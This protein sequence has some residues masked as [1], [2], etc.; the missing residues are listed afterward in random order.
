MVNDFVAGLAVG[1]LAVLG[2]LWALVVY[3]RELR[4][5]REQLGRRQD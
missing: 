5:H 3:F 4:R 2:W 1:A